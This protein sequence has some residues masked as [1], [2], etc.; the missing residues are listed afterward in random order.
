M[1]FSMN[2]TVTD[3]T[4]DGPA[5]AYRAGARLTDMEFILSFPTAVVP[6]EMRGSIDHG[7]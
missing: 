1:P 7:Y 3:M 4:G 2:N 6:Q 5:M